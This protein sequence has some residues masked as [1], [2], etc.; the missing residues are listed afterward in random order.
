MFWKLIGLVF[1]PLGWVMDY[2]N[3]KVDANV[4]HHRIDAGVQTAEIA[5][6]VELARL[7][8]DLLVLYQGWWATRWI[9]PGF[10]WPLI[11]WFGMV[12]LDST[13]NDFYPFN[14]FAVY[15]LPEELQKWAGE[16][17][18]SFFLVRVADKAMDTF[19]PKNALV[20]TV[21]EKVKNKL[22]GNVKSNV[23]GMK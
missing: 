22:G 19:G 17:I 14:T 23:K 3:K 9:V 5:A 8:K 16:I 12:V 20:N 1:K 6:D 13:F 4:E 21:I 11:I 2:L 7:R 10:A 18:L 15:A